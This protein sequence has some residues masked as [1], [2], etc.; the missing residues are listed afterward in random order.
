MYIDDEILTFVKN[1]VEQIKNVSVA[2]IGC[3]DATID[4]NAMGA[5]NKQNNGITNYELVNQERKLLTMTHYKKHKLTK[6]TDGRWQIKITK[7]K[8]SYYA[9]GKTQ[10]ECCNNFD[11]LLKQLNTKQKSKKIK[12]FD[13][14]EYYLN[15]YA[16]K[17]K[18]YR[19]VLNITKN[20]IYKY[21]PNKGLSELKALDID[22]AFQQ[23]R[24]SRVK[25]YAYT[26]L[27]KILKLAYQKEL[28]SKNLAELIDPITF[29]SKKGNTILKENIKII[30]ENCDDKDVLHLLKFYYFTGVRKS[31]AFTLTLNDI[32][33]KKQY[34][35]IRGTK[36]EKSD[37]IIPLFQ[38]LKLLF[39]EM[40]IYNNMPE[41]K[42]F[43]VSDKKLRKT[44]QQIKERTNI[45][46]CIKDFRTT[47]ASNCY[48]IGI[49][50]KV[51]QEWMGHAQSSTTKDYYVFVQDS[52]RQDN[53]NLFDTSF[54]TIINEK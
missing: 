51:L 49:N 22:K 40:N 45:E 16:I 21:V 43:K 47:F 11:A 35:H 20:Y 52:L 18:S 17:L 34:I 12:L 5:N 25:Q 33:F 1:G 44:T 46:F 23:I 53:I 8:K 48:E 3:L 26:I 39:D 15:N 29:T 7:N 31:E 54:D 9:Y 32:N 28:T 2:I 14:I 37:R 38:S 42:I 50:E 4:V 10:R 24:T 19:N 41:E 13:W 30:F 6:R 36:R 27:K